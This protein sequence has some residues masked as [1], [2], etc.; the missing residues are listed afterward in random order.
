MKYFQLW[1]D[2]V[3]ESVCVFFERVYN[4][5]R[6]C[7]WVG[8]S[9][10]GKYDSSEK[11][12]NNEDI[13]TIARQSSLC[14]SCGTCGCYQQI[15]MAR[16][17]SKKN[18]LITIKQK[19][20][21]LCLSLIQNRNPDELLM[22]NLLQVIQMQSNFFNAPENLCKAAGLCHHKQKGVQ[23]HLEMIQRRI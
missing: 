6:G 8:G 18:S 22:V 13:Q 23:S 3:G 20:D 4:A 19:S 1:R 5:M 10:G 2:C 21:S 7:V 11:I 15:E 14:S 9:C 17:Y 12:E 16:S